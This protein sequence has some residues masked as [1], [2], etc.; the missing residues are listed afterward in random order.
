MA[1]GQHSEAEEAECNLQLIVRLCERST[2]NLK[3]EQV[4]WQ[5]ACPPIEVVLCAGTGSCRGTVLTVALEQNC[6]KLPY[7]SMPDYII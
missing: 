7:C 3:L 4:S 2:G 5:L 6:R 1:I